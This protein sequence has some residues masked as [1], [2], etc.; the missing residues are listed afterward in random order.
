MIADELRKYASSLAGK[1]GASVA[2]VK[3]ALEEIADHIDSDCRGV[4]SFADRIMAAADKRE[5]ITA[6]G[7]DYIPCPLDADG[8]TIHLGDVMD[9][10]HKDG[11]RSKRVTG[12]CYHEG[13][14]P[15]IEV[16]EDRLRWH[17]AYKLHHVQP[18]SWESIISDATA[19]GA[20]M[21]R[22]TYQIGDFVE[23]CKRL[24]GEDA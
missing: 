4:Y 17:N 6:F 10:T 24:A 20:Q 19:L 15:T 21:K 8:E 16:D 3:D 23:R 12:I 18:D 11:F 2:D 22:R 1:L 13:G 5:E 7:V 14:Q 9:N